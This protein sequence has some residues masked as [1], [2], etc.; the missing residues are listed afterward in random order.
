MIILT[1][2]ALLIVIQ[3][4]LGAIGLIARMLWALLGLGLIYLVV[5]QLSG[6]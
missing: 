6:G 4:L 5:L 3:A 2:M 1:I